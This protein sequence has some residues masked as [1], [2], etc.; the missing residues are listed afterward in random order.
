[1][2]LSAETVAGVS[3][4]NRTVR[5]LLN[6][7]VDKGAGGAW[8]LWSAELKTLSPATP[9]PYEIHGYVGEEQSFASGLK[10]IK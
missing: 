7:I 9:M 2:S 8:I 4:T 5:S 10:C 3:A 6:M 1:M